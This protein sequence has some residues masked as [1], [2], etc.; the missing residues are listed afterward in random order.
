MCDEINCHEIHIQNPSTKLCIEKTSV[1]GKL[2]LKNNK[3]NK[4]E[5]EK[6]LHE[7]LNIILDL[8]KT[9]QDKIIRLEEKNN[10][11]FS[12]EANEINKMEE[13]S[14]AIKILKN[15]ACP[16]KIMPKWLNKALS[17]LIA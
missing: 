15:R 2:I 12:E 10:E 14:N 13:I 11:K 8:L 9:I 3:N 7:K 1:L 4:E 6:T 16:L 5:E 17:S